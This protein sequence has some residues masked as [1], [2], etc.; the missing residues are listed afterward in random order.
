MPTAGFQYADPITVMLDDD[1]DLLLAILQE[2]VRTNKNLANRP[3][4]NPFV[5]PALMMNDAMAKVKP[6]LSV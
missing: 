1:D 3:C 6:P 2:A 5:L 4:V